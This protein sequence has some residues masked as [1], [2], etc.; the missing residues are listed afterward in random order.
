LY[1]ERRAAPEAETEI[2]PAMIE[3]GA[4]ELARFDR[5]Y[6]SGPDA[7]RRIYLAMA[8]MSEDLAPCSF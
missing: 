7:V 8:R 4:R 6:E 5:D 2:T 1:R 3:A